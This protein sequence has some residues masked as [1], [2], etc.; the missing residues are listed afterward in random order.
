[1][2]VSAGNSRQLNH[3][4]VLDFALVECEAHQRADGLRAVGAGCAR[5]EHEG[6]QR[7]V[8]HRLADVAVSAHEKL[9]RV[10]AQCGVDFARPFARIAA[11]VG[12]PDAHAIGHKTQIFR[13]AQ[14]HGVRV[15]IAP[16]YAARLAG[17]LQPVADCLIDHIAR[18]PNLVARGEIF[19]VAVIPPCVQVA[20]Q[21]DSSHFVND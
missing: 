10:V 20:H 21:S 6:V 11:D 3:L 15:G 19:H 4:Q 17:G 12:H 9:R 18:H 13:V 8:V 1:M 14:V 2:G 7:V 16:H 5:I